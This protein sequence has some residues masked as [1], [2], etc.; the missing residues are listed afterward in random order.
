MIDWPP[1][2][3]KD[4]LSVLNLLATTY[5][6]S[7]GL[8]YLPVPDGPPPSSPSAAIHAPLSLIP[9]PFPR[10][11]FDEAKRLQ[12]FYNILYARIALNS[13]FLDAIMGAE[14]GV[15]Q[16]DDFTGQLWKAWLQARTAEGYKQ[17]IHL[18]LF[19]S[20]YLMHEPNAD[21]PPSLKQVEFNTISSSFGALSERASNMHKYLLSSTGYFGASP[22][23]QA[24]NLPENTTT[25]GLAAGLAEAYAAYGV[26]DTKILFVVQAGERN[27]FDQRWIEYELL[28]QHSIHVVRKTFDELA[29]SAS[30]SPSNALLIDTDDGRQTEISVIYFRAGYTPTDYPTPRH[31]TT[32]V[33]LEQSRA[34]S[35]PS[36]PLQL[37]GGKKVQQVLTMPGM[38]ERFMGEDKEGCEALRSSW[39]GMWGLDDESVFVP[40]GDGSEGETAGVRLARARHAAL[41]LKPQREG[42]GNNVYKSSIPQFLDG[43]PKSERAAWIAMELIS[44]SHKLGGYL[45]RAGSGSEG[46]VRADVVSELGIFGWALFG[47]GRAT[48]EDEAGWLLRT[49]GSDSDEGGIAAG[50]S[51]LDSVVLID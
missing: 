40:E 8:L 41:V 25:A 33:L 49:K 47:N 45:V 27:V 21:E 17:K 36:I 34:I 42:G 30:L 28:Q 1:S 48:K 18:G 26:A 24:K 43:L 51:V 3:S 31:Y 16:V 20:D 15:G 6:L 35:C 9:T 23:L 2:L 22:M 5:A 38:L 44:P 50:F 39:M 7:H 19:R 12:R 37:A 11:L 29:T 32:R 14:E 13:D 46:V 4:D 10:R